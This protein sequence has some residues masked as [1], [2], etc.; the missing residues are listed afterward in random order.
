ME[1]AIEERLKRRSY[2][3]AGRLARRVLEIDSTAEHIERQ[4]IR[5]YER[6]GVPSAVREQ[7]T[8]YANVMRNELGVDP[9]SLGEIV[10]RSD[11][12]VNT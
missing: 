9:P 6:Q 12:D 7:Y 11:F 8:H 3:E 2:N 5:A 10:G 1:R 4:L